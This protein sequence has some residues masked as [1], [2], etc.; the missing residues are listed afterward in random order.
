MMTKKAQRPMPAEELA[1]KI[2]RLTPSEQLTLAVELMEA[3]RNEL[4]M[5]IVEGVVRRHQASKLLGK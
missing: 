5:T 2:L 3:G 1:L 4:A